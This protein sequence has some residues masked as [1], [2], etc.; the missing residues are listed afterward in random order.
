MKGQWLTDFMERWLAPNLLF[1]PRPD[2]DMEHYFARVRPKIEATP[3]LLEQPFERREADKRKE[4]HHS[5]L[6][7]HWLY[8]RAAEELALAEAEDDQRA[9]NGDLD[10]RAETPTEGEGR[11]LRFYES[12]FLD[13]VSLA[14]NVDEIV[15][16]RMGDPRWEEQVFYARDT[17]RLLSLAV[18]DDTFMAPAAWVKALLAA[19]ADVHHQAVGVA[20]PL[21]RSLFRYHDAARGPGRWSDAPEVARL[22][23]EHGADPWKEATVDAQ[24]AHSAGRVWMIAN[25]LRGEGKNLAPMSLLNTEP[26]LAPGVKE[27]ILAWVRKDIAFAADEAQSE[28]AAASPA[29]GAQAGDAGRAE[30]WRSPGR[31]PRRL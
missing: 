22:L 10:P 20:A 8:A 14:K 11:A 23:L 29:V 6:P 13:W 4:V 30:P 27:A 15:S 3:T 19:G 1:A 28:A 25:Q 9:A 21:F 31:A 17:R 18:G 26:G 16:D 7:L 5:E 2:E 12:H 24:S